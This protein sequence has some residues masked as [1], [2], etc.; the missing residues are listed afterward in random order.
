MSGHICQMDRGQISWVTSASYESLLVYT[1]H[2]V[3]IYI[4]IPTVHNIYSTY[5]ETTK[6][7]SLCPCFPGGPSYTTAGG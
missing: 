3:G 6:D 7:P 1:V 2:I 5:C 4:Y